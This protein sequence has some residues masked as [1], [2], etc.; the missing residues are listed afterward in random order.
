M[1]ILIADD[2]IEIT[3]ILS[4]LVKDHIASD[5]K[6]LQV[7]NATSAMDILSSLSVD[8]CICDHNMANGNG[9][10][11][12]QHIIQKN[13]NTRFVL[14]S[15]QDFSKS[16]DLYPPEKIYFQIKKPDLFLGMELLSKVIKDQFDLA[17]FDI[18]I[19]AP[20]EIEYIP[21][22]LTF[23][24][25]LGT[26]PDDLYLK[27]TDDKFLK[28]LNK[29]EMFTTEDRDKYFNR[30]IKSLYLERSG[31]RLS[32]DSMVALLINSIMNKEQLSIDQKLN[33]AHTQIYE[34]INISGVTNE[35]SE[36]TREN[37]KTSVALIMK[38]NVLSNFWTKLTLIGEYP[39]QLYTMH[40]MLASAVVKQLEWGNEATLFKMTMAAFLQDVGL[41]SVN[42]M[43][44]TDYK[45]FKDNK[46]LF[47]E[48]EV[49][50][51]MEHPKKAFDIVC[52]FKNIPPDIDKI[53]LEQNEMPR[54]DGFPR[55]LPASQ[56]SALSCVFIL[57][58]IWARHILAKKEQFN[59]KKFIEEVESQGYGRGNFRDTLHVMKQMEAGLITE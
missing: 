44:I 8:F 47:N 37:I 21:V 13:L 41:T 36:T 54:G 4:F 40:S 15:G 10:I 17:A 23:L 19:P 6:V 57:T 59:F 45:N 38:N 39:A 25:L 53:V 24:H 2:D 3:E 33:I 52:K 35:V 31:D 30:N 18:N 55:K 9:N 7:N 51:F 48:R 34:L 42:L 16:L 29:G 11:V 56:I 5:I 46:H 14:A 1:I 26:A 49:A 22:T 43:Q 32:R 50:E 12:L 58:G 20:S 28:C 27:M